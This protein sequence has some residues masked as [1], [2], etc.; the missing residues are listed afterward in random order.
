MPTNGVWNSVYKLVS[1][2]RQ[3]V[4]ASEES[5]RFAERLLLQEPTAPF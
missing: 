1:T 5:Q 2:E 3:R 4:E